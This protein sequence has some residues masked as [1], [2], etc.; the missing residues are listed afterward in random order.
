[1]KF[2][3]TYSKNGT[4]SVLVEA[5]NHEQALRSLLKRSNYVVAVEDL[6]FP[7]KVSALTAERIFKVSG[8]ELLIEDI[9]K[10]GG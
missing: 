10:G 8:G 2:L 7:F 3:V 1:M 4:R 9:T 6:D 5:A